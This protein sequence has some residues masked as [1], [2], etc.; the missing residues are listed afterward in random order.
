[1]SYSF[2][3]SRKSCQNY[4]LWSE[5]LVISKL[6]SLPEDL[7]RYDIGHKTADSQS[8]DATGWFLSSVATVETT[9]YTWR[10]KILHI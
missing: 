10:M 9:Y 3:L 1:M 2:K 6:N 7:K 4:N 5:K 8:A